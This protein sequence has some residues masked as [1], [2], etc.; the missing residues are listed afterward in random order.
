[1]RKSHVVMV[2]G[3]V[4]VIMISHSEDYISRSQF[5]L[6]HPDKDTIDY[7]L[8]DFKLSAI[9]GEGKVSHTLSGDY[10]AHWQQRKTSF[11][12]RPQLSSKD[13]NAE[14]TQPVDAVILS[15]E[16]ALL[17]HTSNTATLS[18]TVKLVVENNPATQLR[19][20]TANLNYQI[21]EKHMTTTEDVTI[22]TPQF[23]LSGTGLDSRLDASILR[24]NANVKSTYRQ[25]I[26]L[27]NIILL[28]LLTT[29][30]LPVMALSRDVEKPVSIEANSVVFNKNAGT[31]VYAGRVEII[32]GTLRIIA[33]RIEIK[34][35]GNEIQTIKATGNPVQFSQTMDS[36]KNAVGQAKL[37]QYFVKQKRLQLSGNASLKQ[38][39]D[40]FTSNCNSAVMPA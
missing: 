23:Q 29:V 12:I 2:L 28:L 16:E 18:G 36:G 22:S 4:V 3:L 27:M 25:P 20:E 30:S 10:L 14:T 19:L 38:D 13:D 5:S 40:N 1:M 34:A 37:M 26:R 7:Y 24:L 15:A 32:Q 33:D 8:T 6:S 9:T 21:D 35:P 17:D 31:A 11:I 39:K